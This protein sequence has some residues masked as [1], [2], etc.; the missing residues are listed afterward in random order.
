MEI[1]KETIYN[2][3]TPPHFQKNSSRGLIRYFGPGNRKNGAGFTLIEL[4]VGMTIFVLVSG[5]IVGIFVSGISLQRRFLA[6]QQVLAQLSFAIEYMSRAL[7]MAKREDGTFNCLSAGLNYI[8]PVGESTIKFINHLQEDDCQEF[9][10]EKNRI[11]YKQKGEILDLT[12]PNLQVESLLFKLQGQ[13]QG[14]NLQPRVTIFLR[15]KSPLKIELQ[16][17]ISQRRLDVQ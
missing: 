5:I 14:D 1:K 13:S 15:T 8:N 16:T 17:T 9:F 4:L 6:E 11:K 3:F 2:T 12:S 10:L 7:R